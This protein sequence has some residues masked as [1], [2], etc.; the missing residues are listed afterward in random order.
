MQINSLHKNIYKLYRYS[1]TQ[2]CLQVYRDLHQ[3][4]VAD[5][6]ILKREGVNVAVIR[7]FTG[8]SRSSY[9]RSKRTLRLIEK[10]IP[11]PSKRPRRVNK[12]QWGEAQKQLVLTIRRANPTYGKTKIAAILARDHGQTLSE[13][14]VGR[15]LT[16]LKA[17]GLIT[18]SGSAVRAKRKRNF[19]KGHAKPWQYKDYKKMAL[20]ERIQIDHMTVSKNGIT[21]KSFKA[22]ERC[23]KA[24]YA[25]IYSN[26]KSA[27]AKRFLEE[28]IDY[29]PFPIRSIQVDGG[30]EFRDEFE[31]ACA[32]FEIPLIV[33]PP[34]KPQYNGGVERSNRTF[35][36]EF[37]AK[38]NLLADSISTMR[39][40]LQKAVHKHNTYRPHASLKGL[41]PWAYI[42][43]SIQETQSHIM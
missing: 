9:F 15:I 1:R 24:V 31:Q 29:L 40:A 6:E 18:L 19:Q 27:S 21:F 41:T 3:K 7:D 32:D 10:G 28:L 12:P 35:R 42:Q 39:L 26:A 17:K 2:E 33:L 36:E 38:V 25:N 22:W 23:S 14:T 30:S 11:Q 37:Y 5:W 4:R 13:S 20:G 16:H 34:N 43:S 8:C